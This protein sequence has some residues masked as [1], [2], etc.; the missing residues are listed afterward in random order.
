MASSVYIQ[1]PG[2]GPKFLDR[3]PEQYCENIVVRHATTNI[4]D[5][6]NHWTVPISPY[7]DKGKSPVLSLGKRAAGGVGGHLSRR[8]KR[9]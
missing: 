6:V 9:I 1:V 3:I 4:E 5:V 8:E 2:L 7:F